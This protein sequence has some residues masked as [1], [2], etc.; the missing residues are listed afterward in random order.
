MELKYVSSVVFAKDIKISRQ[1]YED[2]LQLKIE[3]DRGGNIEYNG[4]L[5]LWQINDAYSNIFLNLHN[6]KIPANSGY[7]F[8]LYFET[9]EID[10][11][12]E[13]AIN[14]KINIM[15]GIVEQPWKQRIFR[16]YDPDENIVEIGESMSL[17][18]EKI[19]KD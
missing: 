9:K 7:K 6:Q 3:V 15:H 1:F 16:A 2:F 11:V 12:F 18:M 8:E 19:K 14:D 13:K 10:K 17:V 4:G 5:S